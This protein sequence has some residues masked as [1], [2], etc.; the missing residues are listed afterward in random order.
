MRF[1][2]L[3]ISILYCFITLGCK[4]QA[5]LVNKPSHNLVYV[6]LDRSSNSYSPN[7]GFEENFISVDTSYMRKFLT[8]IFLNQ[9]RNQNNISLTFFFNYIDH[10]SDGNKELFFRMPALEVIDSVYKPKSGQ[11][12]SNKEEFIKEL[13]LKRND[14]DGVKNDFGTR[15]QILLED[16]QVMLVKSKKTKGS[17]CS[18]ALN[19]ANAKLNNYLNNDSKFKIQEKIILAFSDL[20]NHPKKNEKISMDYKIIRPGFTSEI[21]Y[22]DNDILINIST[23]DEFIEYVTTFLTTK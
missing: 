11:I 4:E 19:V 8:N 7:G 5:S 23:D 17:D 14:L 15:L 9:E 21:P 3:C 18:G 10:N 6:I 16:I 2:F 20:V 13:E 12:V 22:L 1:Y